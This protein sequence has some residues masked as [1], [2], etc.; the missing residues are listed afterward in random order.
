MSKKQ[1]IIFSVQAVVF[2][3]AWSFLV[4][5]SARGSS[6]LILCTNGVLVISAIITVITM[7]N[8]IFIC[9]TLRKKKDLIKKL[10]GIIPGGYIECYLDNNLTIRQ[11]GCIR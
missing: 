7:V 4:Y 11:R 8:N 3:L 10:S 2:I 6:H 1:R 5:C 9:K